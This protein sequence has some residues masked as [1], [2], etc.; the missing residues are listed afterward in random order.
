MEICDNCGAKV[1]K[2]GRDP[3]GRKI[4]CPHCAFNPLGCR[5]RFGE[6]GVAETQDWSDPDEYDESWDY[7]E[8]DMSDYYE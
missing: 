2:C 5:C 1:E 6:F 7:S 3:N 4:C 8:W